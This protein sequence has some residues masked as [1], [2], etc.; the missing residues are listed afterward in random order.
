MSERAGERRRDRMRIG[1]DSKSKMLAVLVEGCGML[2]EKEMRPA[3]CR[4]GSSTRQP[5]G[6]VRSMIW[7]A[8]ACRCWCCTHSSYLCFGL[9]FLEH[10][11]GPKALLR[12]AHDCQKKE[13]C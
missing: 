2:A 1:V 13:S 6:T 7:G 10:G 4:V 3:C 5:R 11:Q 8:S 12:S 9:C